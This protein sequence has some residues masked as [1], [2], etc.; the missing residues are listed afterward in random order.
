MELHTPSRLFVHP[1]WQGFRYLNGSLA[2]DKLKWSS[3]HVCTTYQGREALVLRMGSAW[4]W[5]VQHVPMCRSQS[6]WPTI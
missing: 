4:L 3:A 2:Y 1:Y 6:T 5:V